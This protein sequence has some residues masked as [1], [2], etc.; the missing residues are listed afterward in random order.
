MGETSRKDEGHD[1]QNPP[2]G[3]ADEPR[4]TDDSSPENLVVVVLG[5]AKK[6]GHKILSG[7]QYDHVVEILK[8]LVDFDNPEEIGDLDIRSIESF[9]ELREKWGILGRI[10]L[11][12]YFGTIPEDRELVVAKAYKKEDDGPTPRHIVISVEERLE[13]YKAGGRRKDSTVYQKAT[14]RE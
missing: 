4:A 11:R 10:N 3:K 5:I 7:P 8:R 12:V 14:P 9:F 1:D 13:E 2:H 6:E